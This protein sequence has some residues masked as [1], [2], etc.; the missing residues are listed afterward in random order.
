MVTH[1]FLRK[2]N[3]YKTS[4]I[5][6]VISQFDRDFCLMLPECFVRTVGRLNSLCPG[7]V[8]SADMLAAFLLSPELYIY[9][10]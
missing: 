10:M 6:L 9:F 3:Q 1:S 4:D 7:C 5:A 2:F 8:W